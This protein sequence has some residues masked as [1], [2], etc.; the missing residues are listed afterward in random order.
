[1]GGWK[2]RDAKIDTR[3]VDRDTSPPTLGT[4]SVGYIHLRHDFY[5]RYKRDP[6]CLWENHHLLQHPVDAVA[7]RDAVL[8]GL[9]VDVARASR[10]SL[11]HNVVDELY[12]GAL[13]LLLVELHV[14]RVYCLD[15][16]LQARVGATDQ[17]AH[18]LD[19]R[20]D[21]F[22][23][24]VYPRRRREPHTYVAACCKGENLLA[25]E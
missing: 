18:P 22:Y 12:H 16:R 25:V 5:A 8:A 2:G 19:G 6:D 14:R 1:M 21:L 10:D 24:L 20:V 23:A 4:Q 11:G 17:F 3:A 7:H 13:G 9:E 15:Y